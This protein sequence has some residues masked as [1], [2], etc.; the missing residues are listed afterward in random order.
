MRTRIFGGATLCASFVLAP[1]ATSP[2]LAQCCD[3]HQDHS[4]RACCASHD[5]ATAGSAVPHSAIVTA[6]GVQKTVVFFGE[7]VRIGGTGP[8]LKGLY[9]IEHD[10]NRMA[11]GEPCTYIY[12]LKN[13][14]RPVVTFRCTHLERAAAETDRVV[15]SR[16]SVSGFKELRE[17]QFAGDEASHGV[18]TTIR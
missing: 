12:P 2:A 17:F 16:Q 11:R 14:L 5:G 8:Y 10:D 6:P 13:Q 7:P 15:L 9:V 18:P 1:F 3:D 4:A